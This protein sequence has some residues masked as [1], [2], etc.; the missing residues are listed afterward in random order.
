MC[1]GVRRKLLGFET[2]GTAP[3]RVRIMKTES[4]AAAEEAMHD[5][6]QMLLAQAADVAPA[7]AAPM[8][9]AALPPRVAYRP[10]APTIPIP[11]AVR[12]PRAAAPKPEIV[13]GAVA[14]AQMPPSSAKLYADAAGS[15]GR[16]YIQAGAFVWAIM[17]SGCSRGS[18]GWAASW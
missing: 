8:P 16:I 17:P 9:S 7:G 11:L 10:P 3:V 14:A 4:I 15:A 18:R 5:S 1:R 2:Q 12:P 13:A 6:G